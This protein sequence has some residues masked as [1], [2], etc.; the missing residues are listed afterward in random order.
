MAGDRAEF[1]TDIRL[2]RLFADLAGEILVWGFAATL[3]IHLEST[4][5]LHL[6]PSTD[7]DSEQHLERW[8]LPCNVVG[9]LTPLLHLAIF[10]PL[11][12]IGGS[13]YQKIINELSQIVSTLKAE[14]SQWQRGESFNLGSLVFLMPKF[15]E[16]QRR[17]SRLR[18]LWRAIL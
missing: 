12:V 2:C 13:C 7:Y 1:D 4:N 3:L 14:G 6:R 10:T 18:T 11:G 5:S 9:I 15:N 8:I 17:Y 16:L